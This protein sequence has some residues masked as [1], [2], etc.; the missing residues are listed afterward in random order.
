[1][2]NKE[3]FKLS[4]LGLQSPAEECPHVRGS[5]YEGFHCIEHVGRMKVS[6]IESLSFI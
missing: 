6:F 5:P 3:I 1:M 2:P 4:L